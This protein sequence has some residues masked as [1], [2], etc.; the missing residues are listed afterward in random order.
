MSSVMAESSADIASRNGE[1]EFYRPSN[2]IADDLGNSG[3]SEMPTLLNPSSHPSRTFAAPNLQVSYQPIYSD[4]VHGE[5]LLELLPLQKYHAR[6]H[7]RRKRRSTNHGEPHNGT[8]EHERI[9]EL[10]LTNLHHNPSFL[11]P[12]Q[13]NQKQVIHLKKCTKN[14]FGCRKRLLK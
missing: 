2:Q 3:R 9:A 14:C 7:K 10:A 11:Q 8:T 1:A 4:G 6:N 12:H 13:I 5:P